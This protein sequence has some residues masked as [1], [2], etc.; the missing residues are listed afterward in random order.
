MVVVPT[1]GTK[2]CPCFR[3]VMSREEK[4][5]TSTGRVANDADSK[6]VTVQPSTANSCEQVYWMGAGARQRQPVVE[7]SLIHI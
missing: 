5:V 1:T 7:L 6:Q 3:R 2:T 4:T